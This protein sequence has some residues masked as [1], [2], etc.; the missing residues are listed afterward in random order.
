VQAE[1]SANATQDDLNF[2]GNASTSGVIR[3]ISRLRVIEFLRLRNVLRKIYKAFFA[4]LNYLVLGGQY[5]L[6]EV[7]KLTAQGYSSNG[8]L[9]FFFLKKCDDD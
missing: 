5:N 6:K 3:K 2:V 9:A 8:L 1:Y 4:P 7:K